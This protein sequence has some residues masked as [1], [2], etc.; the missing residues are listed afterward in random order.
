MAREHAADE[1]IVVVE[2][3]GDALEESRVRVCAPVAGE[4]VETRAQSG[5]RAEHVRRGRVTPGRGD[6]AERRLADEPGGGAPAGVGA[7]RDAGEFV[8]SETDQLGSAAKVRSRGRPTG[9]WEES[10]RDV[11]T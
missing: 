8:R 9:P 6:G 11:P 7:R 3:R 1:R 5:E 10:E 4:R 2:D